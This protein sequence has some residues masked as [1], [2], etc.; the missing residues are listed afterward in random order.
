MSAV[1]VEAREG[2]R[3]QGVEVIGRCELLNVGFVY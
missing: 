1:P 2:V 3:S